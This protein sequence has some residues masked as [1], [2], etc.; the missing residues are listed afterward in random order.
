MNA[1]GTNQRRIT[2]NEDFDIG[3]EISPDGNTV[4]FHQGLGDHCCTIQL[5]GID[6]PNT[7]RT[8]TTSD[9]MPVYGMWPSWP[10]DGKQ[11]AFNA[12]GVGG[13]GDIWVIN[14]DGTGLTNLTQTASGEARPDWSPSGQQ[15]AFQSNRPANAEI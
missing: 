15:I 4:A 3:A 11:I 8:L 10:P 14:V 13:A 9:G 1:D 2:D 6:D 12:P 5:V 7:E